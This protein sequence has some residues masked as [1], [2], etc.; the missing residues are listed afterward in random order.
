MELE[1][2]CTERTPQT[3]W[4][5]VSHAEGDFWSSRGKVE[6]TDK[7]LYPNH[8]FSH[9]PLIPDKPKEVN[10]KINVVKICFALSKYLGISFASTKNRS[11]HW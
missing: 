1:D 5:G 7:T 2:A 9:Q 10:A 3:D 6:I 8:V 4:A 11:N